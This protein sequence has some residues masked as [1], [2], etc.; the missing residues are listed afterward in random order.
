MTSS[1]FHELVVD[2]DPGELAQKV[3]RRRRLVRSRLLSLGITIVIMVVIYLWQREQLRGA[4]FF[5]VYGLV[6]GI[7]IAFVIVTLIGYLRARRQLTSI[8]SGTAIRIGAPGIQ[9]AGLAAPWSQVAVVDTVKGGIGRGPAL[10]LTLTDGRSAALPL[11]Q[12][13]V[14]PATVDTTARAFSGGRHG[15]DLGALES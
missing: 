8:G 1:P 7:S 14:F 15:V 3:A 2:Y 12:V 6:F 5:A 4:G 11:D 9:I 13:T 10:R